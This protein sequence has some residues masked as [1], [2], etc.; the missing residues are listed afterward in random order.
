MNKSDFP[1]F[2]NNPWLVYLDSAA[3]SQKPSYVIDWVSDFISKDYANIHRWNYKLSERAEE[4]YE[5]SK[6]LVAKFINVNS[7][8]IIYTY[9]A[10]YA[11]NLIAQSLAF[12][13]FL[14]KWDSVLLWIREH[15][16]NIL[17]RQILSKQIWFNIKFINI[18]KNH[19]IDMQDF[20]SKYD[21]S[22]KV[23]SLW[24]VSNVTGEIY[25]MKWIKEKLSPDTFFII[26]W[27]Q[28]IPHIQIDVQDLWCDCFIFTWHKMLA[29]TGIWVMYL[30]KKRI[31]NLSPIIS[32]WWAVEDVS[33]DS[34]SLPSNLMK[35]EAWTPDI[36][37]AVSLLKAIQYIEN[38][39]WM[40]KIEEHETVLVKYA[41]DRFAKI[42][43]KVTLIWSYISTNRVGVFS[44]TI[45]WITNQN[46]IWELFDEQN[47]C[48]RCGWHCAYPLHKFLNIWWTCRMSIHLY[49]DIQDLEKFFELLESI[50]P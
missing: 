39:W 35:F 28:S 21:D 8:E 29:Y 11:F 2:A 37:W 6:G 30:A 33:T 44:F 7:D 45:N 40:K 26:D 22:V 3:S 36:I 4:R 23:V 32:W 15:H 43:D 14:K 18:T 34:Y 31:K 47:I 16:S 24:H 12:S 17:P 20:L 9:N 13:W 38:I 27:S 41:L 25:N 1:I 10:N 19:E 50:K 49:N 48:I 46:K 5:Y 42:K